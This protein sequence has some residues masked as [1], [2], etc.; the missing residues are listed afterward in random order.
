[1][2]T[3]GQ[4]RA[5]R[6]ARKASGLGSGRLY[7]ENFRK[8]TGGSY[9]NTGGGNVLGASDYN[10]QGTVGGLSNPNGKLGELFDNP[11]DPEVQRTV[12]KYYQ[13]GGAGGDL[14]LVINQWLRHLLSCVQVYQI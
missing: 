5:A 9:V 10:P 2:A 1:M 11:N 3:I 7:S 6:L 12:Q 8:Q 14:T 4:K 13:G